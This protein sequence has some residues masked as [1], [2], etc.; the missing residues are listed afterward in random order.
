MTW[1]LLHDLI[2]GLPGESLTKTAMRDS[3]TDEELAELADR[4]R[5]GHGPWSDIT[6]R[7]AAIEDVLRQQTAI[8]VWLAGD[9]RNRPRMPD[10]VPRPGVAA[11]RKRRQLTT[12]DK[13]Y[14]AHLRANRGA[15]PEGMHFAAVN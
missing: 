7:L 1:R 2:V 10:P 3:L 11:G 9:R 5:T 14:L 6:M 4:P 15:L 13:A 12:A 8:T